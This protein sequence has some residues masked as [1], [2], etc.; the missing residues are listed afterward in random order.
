M[1]NDG[2]I[3]VKT[4]SG[5]GVKRSKAEYEDLARRARETGKALWE[6]E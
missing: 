1:E 6:T 4:Y 3:T 2:G 5:Y